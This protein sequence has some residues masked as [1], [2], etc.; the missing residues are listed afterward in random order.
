MA[1]RT[2]AASVDRVHR[3]AFLGAGTMGGTIV[4][5]LVRAGRD[6]AGIAVPTHTPAHREKLAAELGVQAFADNRQAAAWASTIVIGVKPADALALL[7]E[8][9][10][11][12][13]P[14]NV[15]ISLCA[16]LSTDLLSAH[17]PPAVH[18]VRVMPNT[19]AS[20][21]AGMAG[22][23]G[24]RTATEHDVQAA[25]TL[26]SAVGRAVAIPEQLQDP[27][28]AISGSGPA[29]VFAFVEALIEAGVTQGLP[30]GLATEL[31]TQTLLGSARL[32]DEGN[33]SVTQLREAVTSPGGTTAAALRELDDHGLRSAVQDAVEACARRSAELA[34]AAEQADAR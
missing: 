33:D 29:Y 19:P 8:I 20:V 22:V 6:A 27:L 5:G 23:S 17:L 11:E 28:T 25:I 1:L 3:L 31:A 18:V 16:G 26:M 7:D 9:S 32:L 14:D 2:P 15:M 4:A 21:G 12:L 30:R 13:G 24:G 34:A 10:P